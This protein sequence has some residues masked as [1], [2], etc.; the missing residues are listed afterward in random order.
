MK[1]QDKIISLQLWDKSK[2]TMLAQ[3][4]VLSRDNLLKLSS[5]ELKK[6]FQTEAERALAAILKHPKTFEELVLS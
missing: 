3:E 6:L 1:E 2:G 5:K 4:F